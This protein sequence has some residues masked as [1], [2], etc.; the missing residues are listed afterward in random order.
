MIVSLQA[1]SFAGLLDAAWTDVLSGQS[2]AS[3]AGHAAVQ[4]CLLWGLCQVCT[5]DLPNMTAKGCTADCDRLI[6]SKEPCGPA[7]GSMDRDFNGRCNTATTGACSCAGVPV[8]GLW[9]GLHLKSLAIDDD[10]CA[11][12]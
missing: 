8:V 3:T 12:N 6:A 7:G 1:R 10:S 4:E 2:T 11:Q 5:P 9:S